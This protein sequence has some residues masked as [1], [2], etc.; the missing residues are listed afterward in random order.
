MKRIVILITLFGTCF[1]PFFIHS[2]TECE[3]HI[4]SKWEDLEHS[5]HRTKQFGGKWIWAGT[6]VFKKRS[7]NPISL[8]SLDITW[9]GQKISKLTGTLFKQEPNKEFL[10][11]E[12]TLISDGQWN[13][14]QQTLHFHFPKKENL[15]PVHIFC[16]V[17][18]IPRKLEP[19][20][21]KGHFVV[22]QKTLP[23]EFKEVTKNKTLSFALKPPTI[24]RT[25]K[26]S[27]YRTSGK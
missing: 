25:Q 26:L 3:V 12:S 6:F 17:L 1:A 10:P 8:E 24:G 22:N 9:E 16:L 15:N 14:T 23:L 7:R 18:T 4:N 20:L 11:V 13:S 21:R 2:N 27:F 5:T 19:V